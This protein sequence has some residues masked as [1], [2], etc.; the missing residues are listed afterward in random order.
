MGDSKTAI[1]KCEFETGCFDTLE[2]G[3]DVFDYLFRGISGNS[4][5]VDVL[6]TLIC[7]DD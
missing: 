4:S 7:F 5:V 2:D 1:F 3:P 6:R